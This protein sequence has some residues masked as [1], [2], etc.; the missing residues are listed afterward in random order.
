MPS[1]SPATL[2]VFA[3][4]LPMT[5]AAT[6]PDLVRPFQIEASGLRGR[7]VRMGPVMTDI[8]ARHRY[9]DAVARVL[10]EAMVLGSL[11]AS[12]L[13]YDGV[14][15]LQTKGDGPLRFLVVD[16]TTAGEVRAYA[17]VEESDLPAGGDPGFRDLVGTGYVAFTVDQGPHTQRYQGIVKLQG[18][19]LTD[20]LLHYFRQSDQLDA[21][22]KIAV[23]RPVNGDGGA[24]SG[25][26]VMLQRLPD[27]ERQIP[28]SDRQDDWRRAMLLLNTVSDAELTDPSIPVDTVL[29]RLFHEDGV[30]VYPAQPVSRGCRCSRD[31]VA[32]ILAQIGADQL[33]E[34][35]VD[36]AVVMTCE[37]CNIDF[38]FD[39]AALAALRAA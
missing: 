6:A 23:D 39:D 7:L 4:L 5:L 31:K 37:Y 26:G 21:A 8:L 14:F 1:C 20:C 30:R 10:A 24:W 25:G 29:F 18:D 3:S 2:P 34:Y 38:P 11:M 33:E 17:R 36:G 32:G 27:A 22:L 15:T 12:A 16:I 35:K 9:P 19:S 13:K 28:S